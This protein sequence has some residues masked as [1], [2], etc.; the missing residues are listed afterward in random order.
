MTDCIIHTEYEQ[1]SE[2]WY[3][4]HM[5]RPTVGG[6]ERII[7]PKKMGLS[8]QH[9]QYRNK[10][11]EQWALAAMPMDVHTAYMARGTDLEHEARCWY[12][13]E[14]DCDV[15]QVGF[16]ERADGLTGGSPDGLVG[17]DGIIEIKCFG[18]A[19]HLGYLYEPEDDY[20]IQCQGLMMLTG[21]KWV[22]RVTYHP[23]LPSVVR[24]I[25]RNDEYIEALADCLTTFLGA[26]QEAKARL[27]ELGVKPKKIPDPCPHGLS[28]PAV[29]R[30]CR[31]DMHNL[32]D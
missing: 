32:K 29:C 26:L 18:A 28:N 9:I 15:E 14:H 23:Q 2:Q 10:L 11:L 24:R 6:Y 5:G 31:E 27:I 30:I 8:S 7:Q 22:D 12:A 21:R 25:E 3:R 19:N 13:W 17:D 16:V 20:P 4:A 1:G